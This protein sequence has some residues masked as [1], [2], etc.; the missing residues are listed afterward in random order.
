MRTIA[1]ALL[2]ASSAILLSGA[3]K[4]APKAT[5]P[6]NPT[7]VVSVTP[8]GGYLRGNPAAPVK[9]VEFISYTCPHCAHFSIEAD[10][11][12]TLGFIGTGKGSVEVR[13][14]FRNP[15]DIAAA[16]LATCGAPTKFHGNHGAILRAQEKWLRNPTQGEIARWSNPDFTTR[17]RAIAADLGLYPLMEARG[18]ARP[19][20][21]RCLANKTLAERMA[22]QNQSDSQI[23]Q[24]K[25]TPSFLVNGELQEG[26]HDWAGLRPKLQ[27]LTK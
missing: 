3:S 14:Y 11:P 15:I 19:E 20:L 7:T 8:E 18:Y 12:L 4:P 24:I 6:R 10:A 22:N 25:G 23:Y 27:A 1:A 2:V 17:M 13:P 9:L 26:V 16:L 21:D 5:A